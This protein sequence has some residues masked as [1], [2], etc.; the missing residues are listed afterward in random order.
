MLLLSPHGMGRVSEAGATGIQ[1][2][3][4]FWVGTSAVVQLCEFSAL[5]ARPPWQ[6]LLAVFFSSRGW[7]CWVDGE[8]C[9]AQRVQAGAGIRLMWLVT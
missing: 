4:C 6:D 8:A 3:M 7:C 9:L 2:L 1:H 5:W